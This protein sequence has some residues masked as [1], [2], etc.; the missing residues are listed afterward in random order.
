VTFGAKEGIRVVL[1]LNSFSV[2]KG[3]QKAKALLILRQVSFLVK[4]SVTE[5]EEEEF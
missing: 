3:H 2:H 5:G 1:T 4:N